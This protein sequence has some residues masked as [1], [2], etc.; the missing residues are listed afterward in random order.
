[1]GRA[2]EQ[3]PR[4]RRLQGLSC[5]WASAFRLGRAVGAPVPAC[6]ANGYCTVAPRS[7]SSTRSRHLGPSSARSRRSRTDVRT[8]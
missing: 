3:L 5:L 6:L 4:A 7:G 8:L 1:M 2:S